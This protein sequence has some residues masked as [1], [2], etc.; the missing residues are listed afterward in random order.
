MLKMINFWNS[1]KYLI[2]GISAALLLFFGIR[3]QQSGFDSLRKMRQMERIPKVSVHHVVPGEVSM[4]GRARSSEKVVHARYTKTSCYYYFFRKEEEKRD[5][6]G[7]KY[8]STVDSGSAGTNFFLADETGRI[9]VELKM[10]GVRPDLKLDYREERGDYR[11]SEWRIDKGEGLFAMA[12]ANKKKEGFSLR[13]D[14]PGSYPPI[15]SNYDALENR[16][17]FG[18]SGVMKSLLSVAFLCFGCLLLCFVF[19]VHRVLVFLTIVSASTSLAM[20]YLG[21]AMMRTDLTDGY[22]RLERLEKASSSEVEELLGYEPDWRNLPLEIDSLDQRDRNRALGIRE[23]LIASIERTN[24]IGSRF[25]ERWLAPLWDI[26]PWPSLRADGE[27]ASVESFIGETPIGWG[28]ST[29]VYVL[30]LGMFFWGAFTG[31]RR[32][33]TKR[34]VENIPTS[35]SAGLA[36]GPAE[37]KGKAEPSDDRTLKGPLTKEECVYYHYV[38]TERRGSGKDAYTVVL[39]NDEEFVPFHCRD[40][41]GVTGIDPQGAEVT[42]TLK[43]RTRSGRRTYSEWNIAP[44]AELYV[45]GS[46]EV[47]PQKGD[48]LIMSDGNDDGFPYLISDDSETEVMLRQSRKGLMRIGLAQIGTIF[49]GITFFASHGSFAATDFLLSALVSPLFLGLSMFVLMFNDLVFLRNRVKRAWANIEVSLK[50]RADLI[51]NLEQVVKT[52]LSHEQSVM[53]AVAR[54]RSAFV[55]KGSYSPAEVDAAMKEEKALAG[56]LIALQEDYPDLKGNQMMEDFMNRLAWME[57]EVALMRSGYNDGIERYRDLKRR[58]PEVFIAMAFR[59][60]DVEYLKFALEV[61]EVPALD[62]DSGSEDETSGE[63]DD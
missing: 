8:W 40:S 38:V 37:I 5:E 56:R 34:H 21:L 47:D 46:A 7:D 30:A 15:L 16:S 60:E 6:D 51:P 52:Y 33:K 27:P 18:T 9:L 19:R 17:D 42:V 29:S 31:F 58:I 39:Q 32:I 24:A 23:D 59:F 62:F 11:Y 10:R 50:K 43:K 48:R 25:P 2:W 28:V 41:E 49:L 22:E 20:V 61:R 45:L 12:M 13:F 44:G 53:D 26:K 55:G 57:N 4:E 1:T 3:C 36:Y 35:K 14:L 63:E 54:L